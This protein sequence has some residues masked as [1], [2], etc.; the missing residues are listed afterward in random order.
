MKRSGDSTD[1]RLKNSTQ[2]LLWQTI[3]LKLFTR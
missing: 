3:V 1:D 2:S